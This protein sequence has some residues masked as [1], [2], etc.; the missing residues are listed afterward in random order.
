M[1]SIQRYTTKP[2]ADNQRKFKYSKTSLKRSKKLTQSATKELKSQGVNFSIG[3][4]GDKSM[5]HQFV[6]NIRKHGLRV[7]KDAHA[8]GNCFFHSVVFI[9]EQIGKNKECFQCLNH[10]SVTERLENFMEA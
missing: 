5:H 4:G 6:E 2:I 7:W 1:T 8:D 9:L 10:S 3:P